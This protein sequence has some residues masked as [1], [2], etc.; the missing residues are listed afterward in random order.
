MLPTQNH[1]Q[2]EAKTKQTKKPNPPKLQEKPVLPIQKIGTE[3]SIHFYR[4]KVIS[5]SGLGIGK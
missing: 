3:K 1:Q 2:A 4:K 5:C